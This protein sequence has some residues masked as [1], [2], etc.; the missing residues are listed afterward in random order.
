M[1]VPVEFDSIRPF[2]PEELPQ[3]FGRLLADEQFR[4][5]L[6]YAVPGVPFEKVREKMLACNTNLEFQLTFCYGFI[7]SLVDKLTKGCDMDSSAVDPS[8]RYT[9]VSNHRDIVLDSGF[10]DKLL[11][12]NGFNTTC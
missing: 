11:I 3:V 1:K 4:Q 10:L 5:V 2:E 12:D 8:G 6:A 9:F 7:Q